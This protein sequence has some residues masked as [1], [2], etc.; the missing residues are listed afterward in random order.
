MIFLSVTQAYLQKE[1]EIQVLQL[2]DK[3][4]PWLLVQIFQSDLQET[5]E[6]QD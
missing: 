3:P 4:K 6:N 5:C 2:E 1:K